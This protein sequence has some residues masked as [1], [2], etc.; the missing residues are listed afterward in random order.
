MALVGEVGE[1]TEH[2]QWIT[3]EQSRQLGADRKRAVGEEIADVLIY[4]I[5][6]ADKLGIDVDRAVRRKMK[7]NAKK[8][9]ATRARTVKTSD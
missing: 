6:L 7:I 5:R 8:Y 9:P 3:E 4:T 1:L 2:F